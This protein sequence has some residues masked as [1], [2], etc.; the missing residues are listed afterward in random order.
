MKNRL[1]IAALA[2][3][4]GCLVPS[5]ASAACT[6]CW[7]GQ[8]WFIWD[9]SCEKAMSVLPSNGIC[10]SAGALNVQTD[11]IELRPNGTGTLVR[12]SEN[13]PLASDRMLAFMAAQHSRYSTAPRDNPRLAGQMQADATAFFRSRDDGVV[14]RA[15]ADRAARALGIAVRG[16]AAGE[17]VDPRRR[18]RALPNRDRRR[19]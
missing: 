1:K 9:G 14:S 16:P 12:G 2:L 17:D 10:F 8:C 4:S 15:T 3:A 11:F 13:T 6:Y 18:E 7:G 19:F 5:A